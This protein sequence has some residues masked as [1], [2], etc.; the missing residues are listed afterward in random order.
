M[1]DALYSA[2]SQHKQAARDHEIAAVQHRTAAEFHDKAML[3]QARLASVSALECCEKAHRLSLL[4]C[5]H[6]AKRAA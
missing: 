1:S 2:G 5:A 4:A 6:S 3:H